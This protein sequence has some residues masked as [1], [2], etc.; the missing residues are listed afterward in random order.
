MAA[1]VTALPASALFWRRTGV[2]LVQMLVQMGGV[3]PSARTGVPLVP[4]WRGCVAVF[5]VCIRTVPVTC[6]FPIA[7]LRQHRTHRLRCT[8]AA[9]EHHFLVA[10]CS[11]C[12]STSKSAARS[13]RKHLRAI[14]QEKKFGKVLAKQ[15]PLCIIPSYKFFDENTTFRLLCYSESGM[16]K[17]DRASANRYHL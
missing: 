13:H 4:H 1:H 5:P 11:L 16:V 12:M 7:A 17:A 8:A 15:I 10:R 2:A 6:T 14:L 3:L 9:H